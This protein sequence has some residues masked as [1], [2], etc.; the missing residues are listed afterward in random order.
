MDRGSTVAVIGAGI[1]GVTSAY[2]LVEAGYRVILLD[3]DE[4]MKGTSFANAAQ[5]SFDSA[6]AMASP[7]L[8][9]KLPAILLGRVPAFRLDWRQ[10]PGWLPWGGRFLVQGRAA[11]EE[12]N[13]GSLARLAVHSRERLHALLRAHPLS[14]HHRRS[15]KLQIYDRAA[16]LARAA[17]RIE[18]KGR[19]GCRLQ[20]LDRAACLDLEPALSQWRGDWVGGVYAP[21]DEVGDAP[22]FA[23][24][25]L[26][27]MRETDR[28]E[29]RYRAQVQRLLIRK[30]H[31]EALAT[32]DGRV[33]ADA[34]VLATGAGG[35]ALLRELELHLPIYPVKGYSLT[36]PATARAP[37]VSVSDVSGRVVFARLGDRLRVAGGADLVGFDTR[38]SPE[39]IDYL[40]ELCRRRLPEAGRYD[41]PL[42]G[43]AG[44]RPVTPGSLPIIGRAGAD[45]L[46]LN[47]GHGMLGWTLAMGAASL[48]A[49]QIGGQPLA[50]A[51]AGFTPQEQGLTPVRFK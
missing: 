15:G 28:L 39:R 22:A 47:L 44:L 5:L 45:N 24:G 51:S 4:P 42:H 2:M 20:L 3:A 49:A 29:E 1:V 6:D 23:E 48:L 50:V 35:Q 34:Y 33:E 8:L 18:H 13:S 12:H 37:E 25:L 17:R 7:A 19:W 46:Y 31:I 40:L 41:E 43:W 27:L 21:R 36:V 38:P 11:R 26:A 10:L 14:F 9:R 32:P 30:W 16:D